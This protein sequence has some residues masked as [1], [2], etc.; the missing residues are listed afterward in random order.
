M[1]LRRRRIRDRTRPV[2]ADPTE[3]EQEP[4]R[5]PGA[6]PRRAVLVTP[7]RGLAFV[8]VA[9]SI[10]LGASQFSNY[11]A[12]EVGAPEY[13]GLENFAP[14]PQRDQRL[15]RSAHGVSVL[16]IAVASLFATALAVAKNWRLARLL[17]FL[18]AAVVAIS[19]LVD[20]HQ[21]LREGSIGVA[22]Q[23]AR[24]VLLAG[25]WVQLWSGVTLMLVGPLLAA[26]LRSERRAR[27]SRL[28]GRVPTPGVATGSVAP[29]TDGSGVGVGSDTVAP[30]TG[31]SGMEGAPT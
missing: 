30:S 12:V 21:G 15:P 9:A 22:Y 26:Q 1:R 18:G 7:A 20:L 11:H 19:L 13:G 4:A 3:I 17:L 24:A 29:P 14:P 28:G 25:F 5:P 16:A 31:G 8:A 10:T 2:G 6:P 23:G 27:R